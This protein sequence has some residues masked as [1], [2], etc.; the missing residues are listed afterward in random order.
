MTGE[1]V[2]DCPADE[3][4]GSEPTDVAAATTAPSRFT[5]PSSS[6]KWLVSCAGPDLKMVQEVAAV[7]GDAEQVHPAAVGAANPQEVLPTTAS[8]LNRPR[9]RAFACWAVRRAR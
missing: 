7:L 8:T 3:I 4:Q 9:A 6:V 2:V 5:G 1:L